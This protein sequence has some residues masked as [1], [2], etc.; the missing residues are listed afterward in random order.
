[1]S[2]AGAGAVLLSQTPLENFRRLN[3]ARFTDVYTQ[4]IITPVYDAF[5]DQLEQLPIEQ[6]TSNLVTIPGGS[7]TTLLVSAPED[8]YVPCFGAFLGT[9][10]AGGALGLIDVVQAYIASPSAIYRFFTG[11]VSGYGRDGAVQSF[12]VNFTPEKFVRRFDTIAVTVRNNYPGALTNTQ[13]FASFRRL[14]P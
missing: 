6:L 9:P 3:D 10:P 11:T 8:G 1:M 4:N 14:Q 12:A 5:A 2:G 7:Q 13:L